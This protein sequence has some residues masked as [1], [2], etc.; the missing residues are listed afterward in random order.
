M[1]NELKPT[2]IEIVNPKK[3]NII[4]VMNRNSSMDLTDFSCNY[5]NK[6]RTSLKNKNLF[7]CFEILMLTY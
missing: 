7:P 1:K 4:G 2:F 5:L 3:S 6:L